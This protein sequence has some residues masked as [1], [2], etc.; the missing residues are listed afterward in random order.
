M[1]RL[2]LIVHTLYAELVDLCRHASPAP[3]DWPASAGLVKVRQEGGEHW[4]LQ[5]SLRTSPG[6]YQQRVYLGPVGEPGLEEKIR[7]FRKAKQDYDHRRELI[8]TL[9]SS[10]VVAP[11]GKVANLLL[12]LDEQSVLERAVLVGTVAFQAYGPM[13]GVRFRE[14]AFQTMDVDLTEARGV[15]I[16][17][18]SPPR[19]TDLL[20]VLKRIDSSFREV[21]GFGKAA[22][23]VS[24]MNEDRLR[25]DILMPLVGPDKGPQPT[26]LSSHGQPVRFLD[27][28]IT[29]PVEAV[30]LV[31]G[32]AMVRVPDPSRFALHKLVVSQRRTQVEG[33][34]KRKDLAQAAQ[35]LSVLLTDNPGG[36]ASAHDDLVVRGP[37]WRRLLLDGL[38]GLEDKAVRERVLEMC[39]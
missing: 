17:F 27:Y 30:L 31:G 29:E 10:G 5:K 13:L 32:G 8:R 22:R 15:T 21:P 16:G 18:E 2:P 1:K 19:L 38:E 4:Y 36:I 26:D 25:V 12:G 23:P 24:Y 28:L 11:T 39:G 6:K 33:A 9:K 35:L 14:A 20:E 37:K 7:A 34:R 3:R